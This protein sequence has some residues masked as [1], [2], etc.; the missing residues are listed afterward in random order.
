[1]SLTESDI[2]KLASLSRIRI[3]D[4]ETAQ[5]TKEIDSILGY[6]EQIKEVSSG[7]Q[8]GAS[9]QADA[10]SATGQAVTQVSIPD[11][12]NMLREDVADKDLNPS[13]ADV[14]SRAPSHQD[15]L[16]KVKKILN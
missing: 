6:V 14:L 15:G 8:A 11:H 5:F 2:K 10:V 16:I 9:A 7:S 13:S 12:R 3:S 1:M 4:E